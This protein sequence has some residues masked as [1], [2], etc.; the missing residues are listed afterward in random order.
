M[1]IKFILL[2]IGI[3]FFTIGY[4]NQNKY[5][6]NII[7]SLDNLQEKELYKFFTEKNVLSERDPDNNIYDIDSTGKKYISSEE[8]EALSY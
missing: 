4:V 5:N 6:C 2:M 8:R 3:F 7:P 1:D